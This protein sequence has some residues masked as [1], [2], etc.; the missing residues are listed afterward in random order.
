MFNSSKPVS[1]ILS[2][3]LVGSALC[4][5][6]AVKAALPAT[7]FAMPSD[8]E[9]VATTIASGVQIYTC[10]FDDSHRLGWV[11]KSPLATLYDNDG[12]VAFHHA[13]GPSW[14]AADGSKI[15][16]SVLSKVPSATPDSIPQLLL[17]TKNVAGSGILAGIRYVQRVDTVGGLAPAKGCTGEHQIGQSPYLARY[18]FLR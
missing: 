16:G 4:A 7:A 15:V 2:V 5:A 17:Q 13:E 9:V 1:Q 10:E 6:G 12:Q 8:A 14:Q 3:M 11:F 18:I